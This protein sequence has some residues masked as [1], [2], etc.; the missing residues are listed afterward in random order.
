M[1]K[2]LVAVAVASLTATASY[3]AFV[4]KTANTPAA[5]VLNSVHDMRG[6]AG[7]GVDV[8]VGGVDQQRVCAFCHTPHHALADNTGGIADYLPLWSHALTSQVNY[9]AYFTK[10]DRSHVVL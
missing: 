9:N 3:G 8:T 10:S 7:T 5:G 6:Y 4:A 2:I 1:K